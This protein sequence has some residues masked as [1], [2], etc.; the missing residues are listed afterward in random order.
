MKRAREKSCI[1]LILAYDTWML[2]IAYI[3]RDHHDRGFGGR[4]GSLWT[5]NQEAYVR[6]GVAANISWSSP[7]ISTSRGKIDRLGDQV[8]WLHDLMADMES[9]KLE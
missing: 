6:D 8:D 3:E 1:K 7:F 9:E 5:Q 2:L 4:S